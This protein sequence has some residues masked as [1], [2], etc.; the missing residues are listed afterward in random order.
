MSSRE[1]DRKEKLTNTVLCLTILLL[2]VTLN[3]KR[4]TYSL[5]YFPEKN[6]FFGKRRRALKKE[7]TYTHTH[8]KESV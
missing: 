2:L 7:H 4:I 5:S 6:F 1:E 3:L 8:T